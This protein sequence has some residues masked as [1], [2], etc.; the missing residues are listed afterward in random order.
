MQPRTSMQPK[1][2]SSGCNFVWD[3]GRAALE[4]NLT[5]W[6]QASNSVEV[7]THTPIHADIV[8]VLLPLLVDVRPVRCLHAWDVMSIC[9]VHVS[10]EHQNKYK[11]MYY[12]LHVLL[13]LL[14]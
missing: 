12:N 2:L 6:N 1:S 11:H 13:L 4:H 9:S 14:D 10:D 8:H 7:T 5:Q 3:R